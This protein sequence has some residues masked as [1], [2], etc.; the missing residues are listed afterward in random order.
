[1]ATL[2]AGLKTF[3]NA[4]AALAA[5]LTGGILDTDDDLFREDVSASKAPR[6]T[7][8]V[9]LKP[10]A[11]IRWRTELPTE[12]RAYS[13]RHTL[14]IY[15]YQHA[16]Y[17]TIRQ[18]KARLKAL[19]DRKTIASDNYGMGMFHWRGGTNEFP[20]VELGNASGAIT[21]WY[22]DVTRK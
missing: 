7:D 22:V 16:G 4:D 13:E 21:R 15:L 14:E 18:A 6:E 1:M 17:V 11:F 19:L 5:I 10:F 3:L 2:E 20:A 12:I 8:G 9:T